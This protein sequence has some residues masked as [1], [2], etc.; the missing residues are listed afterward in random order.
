[1]EEFK[2]D[3][4]WS[5]AKMHRLAKQTGLSY[6]Q[7]YKWRW[8]KVKTLNP[9]FGLVPFSTFHQEE[10][11]ESGYPVIFKVI[12]NASREPESCEED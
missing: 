9:L 12:K 5:P 7:V 10:M 1:M 11:K 2:K 8:D 3:Q 6:A 4:S